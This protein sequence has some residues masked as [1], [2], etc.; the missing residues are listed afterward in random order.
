MSDQLG[1]PS[2]LPKDGAMSNE[3][4]PPNRPV[5]EHL[6]SRVYM[7][8]VGLAL[9]FALSVWGFAGDGYTDYLL[10]VV[11]GFVFIAVAL[12]NVLWRLWRKDQGPDT[13]RKNKESFRDWASD[14]FDTWQHR[15]KGAHAAVEILLPIAA[16]AFGMT[17]F[18]IVL[19]F[20]AHAPV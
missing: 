15:I 12:P 3:V 5:S 4:I 18:G 11:S 19:H 16:V 7:A 13:G 6:H 8:I 2:A 17:A 20:T 9:W 1:R 14:E 10:A